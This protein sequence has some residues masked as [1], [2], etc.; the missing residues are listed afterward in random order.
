M[1][2][3]KIMTILKNIITQDTETNT[4]NDN[5]V[6]DD[7]NNAMLVW[8]LWRLSVLSLAKATVILVMI[9]IPNIEITSTIIIVIISHNIHKGSFFACAPPHP[10]PCKEVAAEIV[11]TILQSLSRMNLA[12]RSLSPKGSTFGGRKDASVFPKDS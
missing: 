8:I 4:N 9:R 12:R 11:Y 3:E 2:Y 6:N 10:P 7:N 1:V 5:Q